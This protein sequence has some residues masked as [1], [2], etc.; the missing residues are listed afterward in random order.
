MG[1]PV[2]GVSQFNRT[3]VNKSWRAPSG[4]A[5][6]VEIEGHLESAGAHADVDTPSRPSAKALENGHKGVRL[7]KGVFDISR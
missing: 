4:T 7:S 6:L 1:K 5:L 3:Q 2:L